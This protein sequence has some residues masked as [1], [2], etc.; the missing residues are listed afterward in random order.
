MTAAAKRVATAKTSF[1]STYS[2]AA[3]AVGINAAANKITTDSVGHIS[4]K[5][6]TG[7]PGAVFCF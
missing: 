3:A 5:T 6:A 7:L 4:K 2:C 1:C